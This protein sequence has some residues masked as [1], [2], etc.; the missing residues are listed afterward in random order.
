M[1]FHYCC[2]HCDYDLKAENNIKRTP[3]LSLAKLDAIVMTT[4]QQY[5]D[6]L[7]KFDDLDETLS[8]NDPLKERRTQIAKKVKKLEKAVNDYENTLSTAYTHHLAGLLDLREYGLVRAKTEGEKLENEIQ[9]KM[10]KSEL[11]KYDDSTI[12]ENL[13]LVKYREFRS[14]ESPT[15]E[16][17]QTLIGH[18]YFTPLTNDIDIVFNFTDEFEDLKNIIHGDGGSADE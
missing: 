14:C 11:A 9:L 5:M 1:K 2:R 7:I 18:I 4:I 10:L 8:K 15:K 13:Y 3:K 12:L 17:I 16:M 6:A